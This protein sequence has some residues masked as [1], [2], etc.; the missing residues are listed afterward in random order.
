M[1]LFIFCFSFILWIIMARKLKN[2]L[3][4][5]RHYV[6]L[7]ERG[8]PREIS[9]VITAWYL[10]CRTILKSMARSPCLSLSLSLFFL[11]ATHFKY[12]RLPCVL[13][14]LHT[15]VWNWRKFT[16]KIIFNFALKWNTRKLLT[17]ALFLLHTRVEIGENSRVK[18]YS[19]LPSRGIKK[20]NF[21]T[22]SEDLVVE[23]I[24][25]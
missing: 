4:K 25:L 21:C 15:R 17:S 22:W 6:N 5:G 1:Y 9:S 23:R 19:I 18:L 13:F 2:R 8:L 11:I 10:F 3:W 7:T 20:I 14:L 16:Y 24:C 12:T